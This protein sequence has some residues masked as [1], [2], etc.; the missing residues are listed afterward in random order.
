MSETQDEPREQPREQ[1]L[2]EGVRT[3][4]RDHALVRLDEKE[5]RERMNQAFDAFVRVGFEAQLTGRIDHGAVAY[6][7]I[8]AE[9]GAD[10]IPLREIQV[11]AD[12]HRLD[13]FVEKGVGL[14]MYPRW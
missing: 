4:T 11:I 8:L 7:L 10:D 2:A 12:Q 13:V 9:D 14:R 6:S 1:Q 5:I 3:A